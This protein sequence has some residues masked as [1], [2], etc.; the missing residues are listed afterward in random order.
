[1]KPG[2]RARAWLPW[3]LAL[4]AVITVFGSAAAPA[5]PRLSAARFMRD[6]SFLASDDL[7]GRGNGTPELERAAAYLAR[8]FES[9]GLT[10]FGDGGSF[11]Q[12]FPLT[13]RQELG[14][15]NALDVGGV[16]QR[17]GKDFLVLPLSASGGYAGA[18]AFVGYGISVPQLGWD[19]YA[20]VDVAGKAVIVLDYQPSSMLPR[21]RALGF[22]SPFEMKVRTAKRHG[23]R[24]VLLV[25]DPGLDDVTIE[26][27]DM[28]HVSV[29]DLGLPAVR[30]SAR[31]VDPLFDGTGHTVAALKRRIDS[32]VRPASLVLPA[33]A[34]RLATDVQR[35]TGSA[36]NVLAAIPGTDPSVAGEWVVIGAHYDHLGRRRSRADG[37]RGEKTYHGADD[38]ASG[39]AG[40]L[41]IARALA[42]ARF[43]PRRSI[44]FAAFAGEEV[45][46][47]GSGYLVEHLPVPAGSVRT[48]LN[49]D[50]IGR[51]SGGPLNIMGAQ[52]PARL[53][54][55]LRQENVTTGL[56]LVFSTSS[57]ATS[58]WAMFEA[59]GVPALTFFTGMHED[60]HRPYDTA[61]KIN[62]GAAIK[63]LALVA[64]AARRI[65]DAGGGVGP[66]Q[67][68]EA[69]AEA[70]DGAPHL[71]AQPVYDARVEALRFQTVLPGSPA[72]RAGLETGDVMVQFGEN[73]M[74][75][76]SDYE[77][78][79]ETFKP[80]DVPALDVRRDGRL[81]RL[82]VTLDAPGLDVD[83]AP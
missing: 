63:V 80:G 6:V 38:N 50:M 71:G 69:V 5:H 82:L 57:D 3:A 60:Y 18:A 1:M 2:T 77:W 41:E 66:A 78:T 25:R 10:P 16:R 30:V 56:S 70:R 83:S 61:D 17:P 34:V 39:T 15:S 4:L 26:S 7:A 54:E 53:A 62:A 51:L 49:L 23:A 73:P 46:L 29:H 28:H 81:V 32:S 8:E 48:M 47:L 9:Y 74:R 27:A 35:T 45:G 68:P 67:F 31:A 24:A 43:R 65:A 59:A 40:V 33:A 55:W 37:A 44:L 21:A 19:D 13:L 36:A 11:L 14:T 20:G 72:E 75:T 64:G 52:V 58:D 22:M 79:L 76:M 42:Q 12:R